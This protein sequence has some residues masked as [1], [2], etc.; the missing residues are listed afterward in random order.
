VGGGGA[1]FTGEEVGVEEKKAVV[2]SVSQM[3]ADVQAALVV[4]L[5]AV[6]GLRDATSALV[7]LTQALVKCATL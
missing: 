2:E 1:H 6:D 4:F 5:G 3:N 7:G